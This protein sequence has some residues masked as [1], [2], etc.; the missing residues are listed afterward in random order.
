MG[1]APGP[2]FKKILTALLDARLD[3]KI[4]SR[5]DEVAFVKEYF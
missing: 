3:R 2:G 4:K 5:E 1:Y